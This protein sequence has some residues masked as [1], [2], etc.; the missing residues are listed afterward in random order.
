LPVCRFN[1]KISGK[2][3]LYVNVG[4]QKMNPKLVI[5]F[6]DAMRCYY[7]DEEL[8]SIFQLFGAELPT[9]YDNNG[10]ELP[11]YIEI[12]KR[13]LVSPE[14]G[15]N[16]GL[17]RSLIEG[18]SSRALEKAGTTQWDA[19]EHH[20]EMSSRISRL[21]PLLQTQ[22]LATEI[23][24]PP[25]HPFFAPSKIRD[26][27]SGANGEVFL[28]DNYIGLRTL[29]CLRDLNHPIRILTGTKNQSIQTGFSDAM[30]DFRKEKHTIEVRR[31][32]DLHDRYLIFNNRCYLI[33]SSI[34]DAGKKD[35][36]MI[37]CNDQA[38]EI[39][40]SA[41]KKWNEAKPYQ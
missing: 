21:L 12:A 13:L 15:Q 28:V 8:R 1:I 24:T 39:I 27:L 33:G 30:S 23:T 31:H 6:A 37:E 19:Q 11:D 10:V 26:L 14:D 4:G 17:A 36:A 29:D 32:S 9:S 5:I 2:I 16:L 18:V 3:A 35:F 40:S 7:N 20:R 41:E 34:K 25:N 22:T 38:P